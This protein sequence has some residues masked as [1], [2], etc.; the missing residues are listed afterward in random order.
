[1]NL[2]KRVILF[3]PLGVLA[4]LIGIPCWLTWQQVR[5]ERLNQRL[6][7]A[8]K[9][10]DTYTALVALEEGADGNAR[11]EVQ[12]LP[13]WKVLWNRLRRQPSPP[14]TAPPALLLT[15]QPE[16][17]VHEMFRSHPL[18]NDSGSL[19]ENL[20]LIKGLLTHGAK[21]NVQ[22]SDGRTPLYWALDRGLN[23]TCQTLIEHGAYVTQDVKGYPPLAY[24]MTNEAIRVD[25]VEMMLQ[26]GAEPNR[27]DQVNATPLYW[28]LASRNPDKVRLLLRY[29]ADPNVKISWGPKQWFTPLSYAEGTVNE[30]A[31]MRRIVKML[32]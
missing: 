22:D 12:T 17:H 32:K 6:I 16:S 27:R 13:V 7:E 29:H 11:D 24:A 15:L 19:K 31:N 26:Q 28:A 23:A 30:D 25:T 18:F 9:R 4:V 2:R 21:V 8:I 10:E 1:M 20:P 14:S 5:H 3:F